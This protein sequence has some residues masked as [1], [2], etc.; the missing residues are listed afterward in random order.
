MTGIVFVCHL[1]VSTRL[2][3]KVDWESRLGVSI[4]DDG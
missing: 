4:G 1:L 2:M 3:G